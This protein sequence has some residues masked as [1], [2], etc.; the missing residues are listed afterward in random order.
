MTW[1]ITGTV[2]FGER[3]IALYEEPLEEAEG[4]VGCSGAYALQ[5]ADSP[6]ERFLLTCEI[7]GGEQVTLNMYPGQLLP[8]VESRL[9]ESVEIREKPLGY[10]VRVPRCEA[11]YLGSG[12]LTELEAVGVIRQPGA[13]VP[14]DFFRQ[15]RL[16][17][18]FVREPLVSE[19]VRCTGALDPETIE[20][21]LILEARPD[22]VSPEGR[23][24]CLGPQY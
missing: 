1:L 11:G 3:P 8:R 20:L 4:F 7:A 9:S 22:Q 14:P 12:Q 15:R 23:E 24:S 17:L 16:E 18:S 21:D 6:D 5:T 2:T 13:E 10:L 19:E